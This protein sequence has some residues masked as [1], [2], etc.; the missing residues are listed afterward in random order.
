VSLRGPGGAFE[1][2]TVEE[3]DPVTWDLLANSR[4][5][6]P[7]P[8]RPGET[9]PTRSSF[10]WVH[11]LP[12]QNKHHVSRSSMRREDQSA[13]RQGSRMTEYEQ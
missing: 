5:K 9:P 2:G 8:R 3:D 1:C 4:G 11:E 12:V 10:R 6:G 7:G 13:A